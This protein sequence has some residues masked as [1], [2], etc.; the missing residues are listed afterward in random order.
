MARSG[1]RASR[2]AS[3]HARGA[4]R[5][6]KLQYDGLERQVKGDVFTVEVLASL[7]PR[8]FPAL[9]LLWI[10]PEFHSNMEHEM[11][12][13]LEAC[14]ANR[15]A[16]WF[17]NR[18][19]IHVPEVYGE[20]TARR[21]MCCEFIHAAKITNVKRLRAEG[22]DTSKVATLVADAF[23]DM[24]FCHGFVHCDPHPGN[25]LARRTD[26]VPGY[27]GPRACRERGGRARPCSRRRAHRGRSERG[28]A[29]GAAGPRAV[30]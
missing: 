8:V 13:R 10:V 29:A 1:R 19:D 14:N 25:M 23:A 24:V 15:T 7:V 28:A 11:D 12:F 21:V 3:P 20:L 6:Q 22:I 30:P 16:A 5:E 17:S 9:D 18:T 27:K 2:S 26:A 4:L